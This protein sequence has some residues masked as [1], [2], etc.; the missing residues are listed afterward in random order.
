MLTIDVAT[1]PPTAI[2]AGGGQGRPFIHSNAPADCAKLI[3]AN[4]SMVNL[5]P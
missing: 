5:Q 3:A 4:N 2:A 1:E